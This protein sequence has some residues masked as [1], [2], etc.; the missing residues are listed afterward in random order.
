MGKY[1]ASEEVREGWRAAL[2]PWERLRWAR[3][4]WQAQI[5]TL[6]PTAKHA[7]EALG[8]NPNTYRALERAPDGSKRIELDHQRAMQFARKFKISWRWLL[9]SHG[10]P[11]DDELPESQERVLKIMSGMDEA[12]QKALADMIESLTGGAAT[13]PPSQPAKKAS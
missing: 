11:F 8:I 5:E 13:P 10:T 7:A 12:R 2:H 3:M 6:T 1:V 9:L 4:H